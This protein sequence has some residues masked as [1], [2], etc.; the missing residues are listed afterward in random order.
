MASL[1]VIGK[2]PVQPDADKFDDDGADSRQTHSRR[3][4]RSGSEATDSK[5]LKIGKRL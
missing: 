2:L 4:T 5:L 3:I 1:G